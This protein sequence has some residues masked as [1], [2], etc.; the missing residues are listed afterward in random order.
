VCVC[1]QYLGVVSA[2]LSSFCNKQQLKVVMKELLIDNI[3]VIRVIAFR[4][5]RDLI[6]AY[7]LG[8]LNSVR[9]LERN[10]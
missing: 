10:K 2:A 8:D 6:L 9:N 7:L 3:I 1:V 4:Q 5:K